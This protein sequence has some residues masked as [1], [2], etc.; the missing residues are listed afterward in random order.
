MSAD[1]EIT[2]AATELVLADTLTRKPDIHL[3]FQRE[4]PLGNG[5]ATRLRVTK[6]D[7]DDVETA[8]SSDP[9]VTDVEIIEMVDDE[10]LVRIRWQSVAN[11]LFDAILE[12]DGTLISAS[13]SGNRWSL[14][15]QFP[16][17]DRVSTFYDR[18]LEDE[19]SIVLERMHN[20]GWPSFEDHSLTDE[21]WEALRA[22]LELG[23]FEV[24]RE[25]TLEELA[26]KF[27]ISDT[28][29]SQRLRRGMA[30]LVAESQDRSESL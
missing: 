14:R 6:V 3:Q 19:I 4:V 13:G 11:E 30:T 18:C 5:I 9:D 8:L 7:S 28:A 24:P 21:Q 26:D 2:V 25:V 16:D 15:I 27:G 17:S 22:A 12:S 29:V 1:V 10:A 20:P 23:Y